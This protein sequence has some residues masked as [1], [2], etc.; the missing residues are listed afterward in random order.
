MTDGPR[1]D[2]SVGRLRI[3]FFVK[4]GVERTPVQQPP[5][6]YAPLRVSTPEATALDLVRYAARIGGMGRAYETL[7]P[8]LPLFRVFELKR[9]LDAEGEAAVAQRLG[10]LIETAGQDRLA[11]IVHRWLPA[12]IVRVPL[13]ASKEALSETAK[14]AR[15]RVLIPQGG[16]GL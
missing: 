16:A 12:G 4:R 8:L 6:A 13:I 10:Y 3:R 2:V 14:S 15:W 9:A 11:E 1:R 7:V 5:N